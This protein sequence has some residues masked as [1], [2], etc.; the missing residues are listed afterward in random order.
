MLVRRDTDCSFAT[1]RRA[2]RADRWLAHAPPPWKAAGWNRPPAAAGMIAFA[3]VPPRGGSSLWRRCARAVPIADGRRRL[4]LCSSG[5]RHRTFEINGK[6]APSVR[7]R[8]RHRP[9]TG[10]HERF[11]RKRSSESGRQLEPLA[12]PIAQSRASGSDVRTNAFSLRSPLVARLRWRPR[13][14][15]RDGVR[16]SLVAQ[17]ERQIHPTLTLEC[18]AKHSFRSSLCGRAFRAIGAV[19]AVPS[20]ACWGASSRGAS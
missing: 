4:A 3:S 5:R 13:A 20:I 18:V 16:R 17:G 8:H 2:G 9:P 14:R 19:T 6:D 1:G 15:E 7:M 11:L 10:P 12:C